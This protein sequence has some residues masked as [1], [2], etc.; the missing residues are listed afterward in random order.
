MR[1]EPSR[2]IP[3][4]QALVSGHRD[5]V[6]AAFR[7]TLHAL[8]ALP[9][10]ASVDLVAIA[11]EHK[12]SSHDVER[13]TSGTIVFSPVHTNALFRDLADAIALVRL[14]NQPEA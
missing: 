5:A 3:E 13:W 6:T 7:T 14:E 2:H 10:A 1:P 12:Y 4:L 8:L 11:A 9:E